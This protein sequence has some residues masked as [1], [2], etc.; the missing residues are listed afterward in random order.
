MNAAG[1]A[2]L[3]AS[4]G[5]VL[6]DFDG[7][8][9]SIFA[10]YPAS[11]VASELMDLLKL[12]GVDVSAI[13]TET[14]PLEILKWTDDLGSDRLTQA[15]EDALREKELLAV[16]TATP[17]PFADD[18]VSVAQRAGRP[19]AIVSNNSAPAIEAYLRRRN[20]TPY[21]VVG[22]I[23]VC[24]STMKPSPFSILRAVEIL[25]TD[26][27][28]CVLIGD[29]V[30]D[31]VAAQEAGSVAIGYANKPGKAAQLM[32]A[33][34]YAVVTTLRELLPAVA[35]SKEGAAGRAIGGPDTGG[36]RG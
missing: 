5:P 12:T 1:I 30:S 20:I 6:L 14:D 9:C 17:T 13:E 24:P 34:A 25:G 19:V 4:T 18:L 10:G 35:G 3:F 8:V 29:S 22:R 11:Q 26:P 2:A 16:A 15:V 28:E 7:P 23:Y 32:K 31:V 36:R 27:T 33:G 21:A